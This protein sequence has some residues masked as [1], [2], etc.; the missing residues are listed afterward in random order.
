LTGDSY[1]TNSSYEPEF[2]SEVFL[3]TNTPE[4]YCLKICE[5]IESGLCKPPGVSQ[6]P[7]N[8]P[9]PTL[10]PVSNSYCHTI[11]NTGS[12]SCIVKWID[13]YTELN[14]VCVSSCTTITVCALENSVISTCQSGG[15]INIVM[16][17][18]CDDLNQCIPTPTPT[19]TPSST[20]TEVDCRNYYVMPNELLFKYA[21]AVGYGEGEVSGQTSN[22]PDLNLKYID[23]CGQEI[24]VSPSF[25]PFTICARNIIANSFYT[26]NQS[27]F[28]QSSC[29]KYVEMVISNL[30]R[31]LDISSKTCGGEI[32]PNPYRDLIWRPGSY[33]LGTDY[34]FGGNQNLCFQIGSF[35]TNDPTVKF[36]YPTEQ[37]AI[38]DDCR[39]QATPTATP[40]PT[41]TQQVCS[42]YNV[43]VYAPITSGFSYEFKYVN[44]DGILI[45]DRINVGENKI[46]YALNQNLLAT[47]FFYLEF[48]F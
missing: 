1:T 36:I 38:C 37:S 3:G 20:P 42:K 18:P 22:I 11:E 40:T 10:T 21:E 32:Y 30:T 24:T 39:P 2:F 25:E 23:C 26:L 41:S 28:C 29:V 45:T 9:T 31:T 8:T 34:P 13:R 35:E 46:I 15:T 6:T 44:T 19:P 17:S 48:L 7:T 33:K 5:I 43:Y 4:A 27:G 16:N 47:K 12:Q 14:E